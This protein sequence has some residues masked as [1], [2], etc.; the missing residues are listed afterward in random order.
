MTVFDLKRSIEETNLQ[1]LIIKLLGCLNY[2]TVFVYLESYILF[3]FYL[4]FGYYKKSIEMLIWI[5]INPWEISH[6]S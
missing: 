4:F 1:L 3:F 5:K 6:R 2:N